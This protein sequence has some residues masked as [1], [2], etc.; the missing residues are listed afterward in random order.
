MKIGIIFINI[1]VYHLER[2]QAAT[3]LLQRCGHELVLIELTANTFEHPWKI[4]RQEK[5]FQWIT[6]LDNNT[7]YKNSSLKTIAKLWETLARLNLD[8]L[9]IAGYSQA[10]MLS[11]LFWSILHHKPSIL[12]SDSK[13][14]DAPRF[15]L[16]ETIKAWFVNQYKAALVAGQPQKRYL[17]KLGMNPDA[18]FFGYDVVGNADFHP[19]K[20]KDLQNPL[21]KPYFL[22]INRFIPK[23]NLLF[24]IRTYAEYYKIA[25]AEAW[26]LVLCGDGVLRPEIEQTITE[27]NLQGHI[28]L[29]GFLQQDELFPYFAHAGC[30]IHA[31]IQEQW[32]LVVN[33]A[34]AAGLPVL[35]SNRCGCFEDLVIEGING[36]GFDPENQQELTDLM[37]KIS[38]GK[39]DLA[40]LGE[41]ALEQ[42]QKFSPD[43][44]AQSLMQA[45]EYAVNNS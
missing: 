34:M 22:A 39:V 20:I 4:K 13:E 3:Q 41:A 26:E 45:V 15:W 32:G 31:S 5:G 30:F 27:L 18:I 38:S 37:L 7:H 25:G 23:K 36:F 14:D 24:L 8:L 35:V 43:Y 21:E 16:Q 33:E 1:G 11:A 17:V 44:F 6:I 40:T 12:F 29:P 19:N 42:I 28:H 10:A 2:I 9:A